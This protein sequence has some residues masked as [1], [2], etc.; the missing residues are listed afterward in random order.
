[1]NVQAVIRAPRAAARIVAVYAGFSGLW[2][3]FS[4]TLVGQFVSDPATVTL[5]SLVKGWFFVAVTSLLLFMLITRLTQQVMA[6]LRSEHEALQE[7][8]QAKT[9]L[10]TIA[11]ISPDAIYAKDLTGRYLLCNREAARLIGRESNAPL[12][13]DDNAIFPAEQ[14]EAMRRNDRQVIE[15]NQQVT[16]EETVQTVDGVRTFL[17]TKGPLRDANGRI[18]GIF[19]I[20]RDVT[21]RLENERQLR[22]ISLALD[23][24]PASVI[25]TDIHGN[26]EYVND[27]F[28][29]KTGYSRAEVIG[30]NPRL[31]R[32][33]KTSSHVFLGLWDAVTHG[34]RWQGE[35]CNKRRDG[36]EYVDAAI[37]T[38]LRETDG[39]ITHYVSVQEDVTERKRITAELDQHRHHL[40]ELVS[41]RTAEATQA[42]Q[43]ADAANQAKS[44][45][46]ANMSHEIRTPMNA[47]VGLTHLLLRSGVTA[48]QAQRLERIENASQHLLAIINDVLD[49]SK[50]EANQ[51]HLETTDFHLST[52][53][54]NVASIITEPAQA[55]G[56]TV[57]TDGDSVPDWLCG[58]PTRLRQSLLNYA[59][60]AVK[61]TERGS[62]TLAARLIQENE[63]E[64]LV[65]FEVS[66]TGVGIASETIEHLFQS[67]GQAD[68]STT[69][70]YGGTGL[71]LAITRRLVQLM[72]GEVGVNSTPGVGSTFWFTAP[73]RRGHG[74]PSAVAH[75]D[76]SRAETQLRAQHYGAHILLAEDH[77][78]NREVAV[79]LLS[80]TGL[81]VDIANDGR[82]ALDKARTGDYDLI[83][84]DMQMPVMNGLDATRAI[85]ALPGWSSKPIVAMTANA[86]DEDRMACE[87]AGMNDFIG[88]PVE[89]GALYQI[90]LHWLSAT[91]A[92]AASASPSTPIPASPAPAQ[93]GP[94]STTPA[95][96]SAGESATIDRLARHAGVDTVRAL[97]MLRGNAAKYIDLLGR[98]VMAH[99]D[100]LAQI[101]AALAQS[102]PSTAVRIAHTL[103]GTGATLGADRLAAAAAQLEAL[104]RTLGQTPDDATTQGPSQA[105]RLEAAS[106]ALHAEF[107]ALAAAQPAPAQP[108]ASDTLA[109]AST[110][111]LAALHPALAE[112]DALLAHNDADAL[113]WL[114]E[115][116]AELIK[117]LG[118]PAE[119]LTRQIDAFDF[120]NARRTLRALNATA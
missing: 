82:Q 63:D 1:M 38:P 17:A 24:S 84:M 22:K 119:Q 27:A 26:I 120:E 96:S 9:L 74:T 115:H 15:K 16:F 90:L 76:T 62:V 100:D 10:D 81:V 109:S 3:L 54:D 50:I 86:F 21:E 11:D 5:V 107:V 85:R 97:T 77:P 112:L 4:D 91:R 64:L 70:Q 25:I 51:L 69:R 8:A 98:F 71:G 53:L 60:N 93:D 13:F 89:P 66:D 79:E 99:A 55:K 14:A 33:G 106:A 23:Q 92:P 30:Q 108:S 88:K 44:A 58:D 45:F 36:S 20:A 35:F 68:A 111:D 7:K 41:Q 67:F 65:R 117:A 49:L 29:S 72:G 114:D 34:V 43:Q 42:R 80:S 95:T 39:T 52:I 31:L 40:E 59:G 46:L 32:S 102:D 113:S 73:L 48:Q 28:V 78:I 94:P 12:G 75:Y 87:A 61:F 110:A 37:V 104:L 6:T 101:D 47:I 56:L 19:G 2:I 118:V 57:R 103:K 116:R 83:L 105:S 18:I